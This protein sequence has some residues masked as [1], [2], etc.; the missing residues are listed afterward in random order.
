MSSLWHWL[1]ELA[2]VYTRHVGRHGP[3]RLLPAAVLPVHGRV[4]GH[5]GAS[6]QGADPDGRTVEH[7]APNAR[8]PRGLT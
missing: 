6:P 2:E 3:N 8:T 7:S 4:P 5:G 1:S